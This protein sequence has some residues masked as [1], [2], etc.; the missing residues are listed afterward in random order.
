VSKNRT[1][2]LIGSIALV[3][4]L[5]VVLPTIGA[6]EKKDG[7]D[8]YRPLGLFTEVIS[9]VRSQ[10]VEPVEVKPLMAG[11]F[12]GMTEAMDPFAEY[13]PPDKMAAFEA[14]RAAKEKKETVDAGVILAKR[15]G[16]P[17]VVS[18]IAGSPAAGAGLKSDDLIEK[19]DD[20]PARGMAIWEAEARLSG[21]A[22]GRVKLLVVRE[23][24]PRRRTIEI[25]RSGWTPLA[26]SSSRVEGETVVRIPSFVPGTA[27]A[28]KEALRP[29][30]RTKPVILD[31]RSNALG[32]FD[33]AA[34]AAALFVTA[35]PLGQ[36]KG[37]KIDTKS[38][39][40]EPGERVHESRLVLLVDSGT[41]GA[42]EF[43]A[44]AVRRTGADPEKDADV[45]EKDKEK[46]GPVRLVGEPTV[47]MGFTAQVVKLSSG[48]ALKLSVGKIRTAS[49]KALS[50]R[51]LEPDDRVFIAPVDEG[52]DQPAVD[53]ILQRGLKVL[54]EP[55]T[56][57]KTAA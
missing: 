42:A 22:G 13:I 29:L 27:A 8:V 38:F 43:F 35:G 52:A 5:F 36:L 30:D 3:A 34:R 12:A 32:D 6:E 54:A 17:I 26:P 15:L 25:V 45:K 20:T 1:L 53:M 21:K 23:G 40:A 7:K 10:Y 57:A 4:G 47:G 50:P 33:E 14:A 37:K 2:G 39:V 49:G 18:A 16:Y 41:A 51:G 48:G 31:L 9:L 28:L 46:P 11:A 56:V 44:A 55:P 24:K 19:I